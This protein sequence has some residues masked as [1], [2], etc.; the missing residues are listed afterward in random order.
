MVDSDNT[1]NI[2]IIAEGTNEILFTLRSNDGVGQII[3]DGSSHGQHLF[4]SFNGSSTTNF[5]R[6]TTKGSHLMNKCNS[7]W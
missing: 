2:R 5:L 1:A 6:L 3:R 4:Q 7:Y